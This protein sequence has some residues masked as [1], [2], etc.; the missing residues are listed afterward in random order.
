MN[1]IGA[2]QHDEKAQ[3]QPSGTLSML[4]P[5][6]ERREAVL[7]AALAAIIVRTCVQNVVESTTHCST[8]QT[9]NAA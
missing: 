2:M 8:E 4:E 3:P 1:R 9:A 6:S 7:I 5:V